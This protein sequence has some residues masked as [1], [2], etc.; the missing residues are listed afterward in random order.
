[1]LYDTREA[2]Q[3][4]NALGGTQLPLVGSMYYIGLDVA[5]LAKW[6]TGTIGTSGTQV[7][8]TTG[9]SIYFSDRRGEVK[10]TS[11]PASV[12]TTPALTGGFGYEDIVKPG[13]SRGC[14]NGILDQGEDVEGDYVNGVDSNPILRTYGGVP[15]FDNVASSTIVVPITTT[16]A[17]LSN[18]PNCTAPGTSWP[19]AIA[20]HVQDLRE[21]P[22]LLF[23]GALKVVHGDTI[24]LGTCNG[25]ACGLTIVSENTVYVRAATT[26]RGSAA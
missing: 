25:V 11:P 5:D 7:L 10:D 23:R 22:P 12:S 1:M 15:T 13:G 9:Y 26:T 4:D 20:S 17:V 2:L 8:A 14:K 21:N 16:A 19:Y 18:N 3:R 24:S 6:F